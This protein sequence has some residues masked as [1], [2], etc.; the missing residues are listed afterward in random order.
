MR[1]SGLNV[2]VYVD[3]LRWEQTVISKSIQHLSKAELKVGNNGVLATVA[4]AENRLH[5][6][7]INYIN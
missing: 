4:C 3:V 1:K 5:V 6:V 2:G 7:K